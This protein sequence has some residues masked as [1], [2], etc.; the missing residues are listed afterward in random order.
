MTPRSAAPS[1]DTLATPEGGFDYF[2]TE[3]HYRSLAARIITALDGFAVVVVTAD[4]S[5]SGRMLSAALS[6]VA[7]IHPVVGFSCEREPGAP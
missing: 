7:T 5:P 4:P 6:E 2:A 3:M 1:L